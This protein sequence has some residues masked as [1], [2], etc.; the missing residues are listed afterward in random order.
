MPTLKQTMLTSAVTG[1]LLVFFSVPLFFIF[2]GAGRAI[3][4]AM[5]LAPLVAIQ[6]LVLRGLQR[7]FRRPSDQTASAGRESPPPPRTGR[8]K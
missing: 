3:D 7:L 4:A 2:Y 8:Q 5:F 6:W 1:V